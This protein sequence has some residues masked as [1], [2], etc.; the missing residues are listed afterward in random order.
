[1]IQRDVA[2]VSAFGRGQSLAAELAA[3]EISVTLVDVTDNLGRWAP[4]DWEGP[5]GCLKGEKW[6]SLQ[7]ARLEEDDYQDEVVDG[8]TVWT[9]TG[10]YELRGPLA[11]FWKMK[12]P[13]VKYLAQ[14][15]LS[16]DD[17]DPIEL[18]ALQSQFLPLSFSENWFCHLSHQLGATF[19]LDNALSLT[20]GRALDLFH[21]LYIRRVTRKGLQ[22]S[23]D[24]V[25]RMGV[26]VI[27]PANIE[28]L[29]LEN[30]QVSGLQLS[31]SA[32][33]VILSKN[34]VWCLSSAETEYLSSEVAQVL[35]PQGSLEP[36]WCWMRWRMNGAMESHKSVLPIHFVTLQDTRL[37]WVNENLLVIQK[38]Q[39][40]NTFDVWARVPYFHRFQKSF[41]EEFARK[42]K[43]YLDVK[44]PSLNL[45]VQDYPQDYYY[46]YSELGPALFPVFDFIKKKKWK[47]RTF[48]NVF[49]DGVEFND[50]LDWNGRFDQQREIYERILNWKALETARLMKE[51]KNDKSLHSP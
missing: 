34:L 16:K 13:A 51:S 14:Y 37:P 21:P 1:M 45:A 24:W 2:I 44:I 15:L 29:A 18:G 6:S 17:A 48:K 26:E 10:P 31:G 46:N 22:K 30:K 5:F 20:R 7:K 3:Q 4:E 41:H 28:D 11:P 32:D 12:D 42:I 19:F 8:F 23:L 27:S 47:A 43:S 33:R 40:E 50:R 35:F 36:D 9:S 38:A 49:Y 39:V 25:K